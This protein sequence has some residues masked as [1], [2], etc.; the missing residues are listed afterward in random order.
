MEDLQSFKLKRH[1]NCLSSDSQDIQI[2]LFSDASEQGFGTVA[3]LRY[4]QAGKTFC[5]ML[6]SK[7]HVAPIKPQLSM[8][9]LEL[10]GA[11]LAV[12]LWNALK[13]ELH[14]EILGVFF[15]TD[16]TTGLRY[17]NN[18][19]R[20]FKP[21]VANRVAEILDSSKQEQWQYIHTSLNPADCCTRGLSAAALVEEPVRLGG[22]AF[23][24]QGR[25]EGPAQI[26]PA[27]LAL[28]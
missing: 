1:H 20:R 26:N 7:T 14:L 13:K 11:G 18:K 28:E 21:S 23:L 27:T 4:I 9:R 12:R 8:P 2:H 5:S 15:W 10:Q 25:V 17:V 22:L 3:Y 19:T 16:S 6:A 24:Q